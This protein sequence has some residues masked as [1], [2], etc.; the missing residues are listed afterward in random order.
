MDAIL[1]SVIAVLGT[2]L[3]SALT[4]VFQQ[5]TALRAEQ[6][7]R[8]AHLRQERLDVYGTYAAQLVEFRQ[9]MV[10]HWI[11][12]HEGRDADDEVSLRRRSYELRAG[13]QQALFQLQLITDAPEVNTAA[14][15][16]FRAIGKLNRATDR[17]DLDTRRESARDLIDTFVVTA[18]RHV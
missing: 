7:S 17:A 5:R 2:L 14:A 11:C 12:V 9:A 4:H 16:A 8:E 3:G 10:H 18:R 13:A 15:E 6:S 1:T